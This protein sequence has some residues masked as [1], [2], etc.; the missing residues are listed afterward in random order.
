MKGNIYINLSVEFETTNE[1]AVCISNES[2]RENNPNSPGF[3][4]PLQI[5]LTS[6]QNNFEENYPGLKTVLPSQIT[7]E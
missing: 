6:L 1:I 5:C 2:H 3:I 7:K 4:D